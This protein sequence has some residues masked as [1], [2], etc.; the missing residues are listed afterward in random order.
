MYP[1]E[2]VGERETV[3]VMGTPAFMEFVESIQSEGVVFERV[4]MGKGT[5][6]HDSLVVEVDR[7]NAKKDID[8]LDISIPK[9]TRRYQRQFKQLDELD[10]S[11]FGNARLPLKAFSVE[12]TR[13]IVF[14]T[15]LDS[16]IH[17]TIRIDD[18]ATVDFRSV[19]GFFARQIL[20]ELRLVG[21]YDV[22]YGK[23]KTF[24]RDYLFK[25]SPVDVADPVV[26]RNLSEPEAGKVIYDSF[27]TAINALTL[28][29]RGSAEVEGFIRLSDTRPFRTE[30]RAYL[31]ASKSVFNRVV[32]EAHSGG[33][34]LAFA[35]FLENSATDVASF[36]KNYLAVGFKLDY[37]KA[38]GELST[39][40]PDFI[41]RTQDGNVWIVETKG[42]EELDLPQKMKRLRDWCADATAASASDT[43]AR[44]GFVFVDQD[45]F[46]KHLPDSFAAL[47]SSFREYQ[48]AP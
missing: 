6:R 40:T 47:V 46:E 19:I 42:R 9:L 25:P 22:V 12:E 20:G 28:Q 21:G 8:A 15:M 1:G 16:N 41:V 33:L 7:E 43:G 37:V 13:E 4:P 30:H 31:D 26:L 44:Y 17:H 35:A 11:A 5:N 10:P 14:K 3:A 39:Y 27:K 2:D 32:G 38:D 18:A 36:A 23:M 29:Y 45:G 34:E 24:I 48:E